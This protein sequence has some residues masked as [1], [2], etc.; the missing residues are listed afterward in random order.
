MVAPSIEAVLDGRGRPAFRRA[1]AP[2]GARAQHVHDAA[3]HAAVVNA[4]RISFSAW[5][6]WFDPP[7]ILLAQPTELLPHQDV[8]RFGSLESHLALRRKSSLS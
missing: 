4:M 2:A 3:D 8:P 6:Q 7:S 5:Q 1:V